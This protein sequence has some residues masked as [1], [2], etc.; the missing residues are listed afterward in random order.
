[1][2]E[3]FLSSVVEEGNKGNHFDFD[4]IKDQIFHT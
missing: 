1:M 3:D 2:I 4:D